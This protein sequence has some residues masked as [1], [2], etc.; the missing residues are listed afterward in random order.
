MHASENIVPPQDKGSPMKSDIS[1]K[2][3]NYYDSEN[4]SR[5]HK[6]FTTKKSSNNVPYFSVDGGGFIHEKPLGTSKNI[7]LFAALGKGLN[8]HEFDAPYQA[9]KLFKAAYQSKKKGEFKEAIIKITDAMPLELTVTKHF[10]KITLLETEGLHVSSP[11]GIPYQLI[12]RK[13]ETLKAYLTKQD[14]N[15]LAG[16]T[17]EQHQQRLAITV[18]NMIDNIASKSDEIHIKTSDPFIADIAQKYLAQLE[19]NDIY[20][21]SQHIHLTSSK[22][23]EIDNDTFKKL[24]NE[25]TIKS[26]LKSPVIQAAKHYREECKQLNMPLKLLTPC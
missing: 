25:K 13:N 1:K 21:D 23:K 9:F 5:F 11:S 8:N 12:A 16:D 3:F 15:E 14:S 2:H 7:I 17:K 20:F 24:M 6:A 22:E 18:M 10:D 26:W 19:K 4:H